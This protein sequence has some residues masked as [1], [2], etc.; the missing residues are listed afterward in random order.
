M[1]ASKSTDLPLVRPQLES[2][3]LNL[4]HVY[5]GISVCRKALEQQAANGDVDIS[6]TLRVFVLVKLDRQLVHLSKLIV[7][8]GGTTDYHRGA[9]ETLE[10]DEDSKGDEP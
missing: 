1:P 3:F 6:N 5:D 2:I 4:H 9:D 8:F 10:D 7:E